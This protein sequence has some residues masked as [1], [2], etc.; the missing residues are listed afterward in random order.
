M[1]LV[2]WKRLVFGSSFLFQ[3]RDDV[4]PRGLGS[5]VAPKLARLLDACKVMTHPAVAHPVRR[6]ARKFIQPEMHV[7]KRLAQHGGRFCAMLCEG[8]HGFYG[9]I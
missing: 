7:F 8:W 5:L 1:L 4:Q 9:C 2:A 3:I 6:L